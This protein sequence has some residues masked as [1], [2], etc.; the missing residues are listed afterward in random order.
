MKLTS[1]SSLHSTYE[2]VCNRIF[3]IL[4]PSKIL[5]KIL[6][7]RIYDFGSRIQDFGFELKMSDLGFKI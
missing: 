7:F 6:R 2:H 1:T 4:E 3:T 5:A